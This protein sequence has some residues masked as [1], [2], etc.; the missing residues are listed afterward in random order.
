MYICVKAAGL[1]TSRADFALSLKIYSC[2]RM[3]LA[4]V[5]WLISVRKVS[6]ATISQYLSGLRMVHLKNG[7]MPKNLRP[8]LVKSILKGHE[9]NE[10][11][12]KIPRLAMTFPVMK[13]L[14]KLLTSSKFGL[15]KKCMLWLVSCIAFHGSMRIHELLSRNELTFDPTTTLLGRD[16][17]LVKT[18]VDG[19]NEEIMIIHLKSP[20]EDALKLGVNV[21]LFSTGTLTCPIEAWHKWLKVKKTRVDPNKPVFRQQDGKCMTGGLF[22]KELRSLLGVHINYDHHKFLSHSFRAGYASM[23]AA[24][25]YTDSEIMRQG[26][27]HSEAFKAYCKTG[28][29][30]RLKEQGYIARRLASQCDKA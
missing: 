20:K 8:D 9:H 12:D 16:V 10:T 21:E 29:G 13:L 19:K 1:L 3:V 26:R 4:F 17:R 14:K 5:G 27:W 23:M 7:V 18:K 28:R 11:S 24:A 2:T 6:S 15:E 22:N 30:G 25:G